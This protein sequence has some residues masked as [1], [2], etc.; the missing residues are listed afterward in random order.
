[1]RQ[2]AWWFRCMPFFIG[3]QIFR[4]INRKFRQQT[5]GLNRRSHPNVVHFYFNPLGAN[6]TKWQRLTNCF[7]VF[8][9]FMEL[10]L[11]RLRLI[12]WNLHYFLMYLASGMNCDLKFENCIPTKN[13]RGTFCNLLNLIRYLIL[14]NWQDWNTCLGYV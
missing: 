3:K 6:P 14:T 10:A 11:K 7:S 13:I 4:K 5:T 12:L 2:N 9:H 8:G 1:M